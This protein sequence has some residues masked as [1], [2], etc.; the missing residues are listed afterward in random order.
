MSVHIT[1][2]S[3]RRALERQESLSLRRLARQSNLPHFPSLF[4]QA[5]TLTRQGKQGIIYLGFDQAWW[6]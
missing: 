5:A 3:V 4:G 6:M 1:L 2:G